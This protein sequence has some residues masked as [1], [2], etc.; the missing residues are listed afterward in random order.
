[1]GF[2]D[3]LLWVA[4]DL[5]TPQEQIRQF[6]AGELTASEAVFSTLNVVIIETGGAGG[7]L[8]EFPGIPDHCFSTDGEPGKGMLSKREVRLAILS[9]LAPKAYEV[10]WDVGA[11]CG[12]V[13]VEW[14]RWNPQGTV[15]AV[16]CREERR[17]HLIINRERFGVI[18]NLHIVAGLAPEVLEALPDP[19]AVFVGGSKGRLRDLLD[20]V[21]QRLRPGG[22]LVASAVTE[23]SRMALYAFSGESPAD[24]REIRIARGE[25]LGGQ[26]LLRPQLPVLLMQLEKPRP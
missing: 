11:G 24:F 16:E 21:W 5:G 25:R 19:D 3:S 17:Q 20:T 18:N 9:L 10:G 8:P 23:D 14:A 13:A 7:I 26:R 6:Q 2:G 1:V 15:Y 22:R 4:E 12:S